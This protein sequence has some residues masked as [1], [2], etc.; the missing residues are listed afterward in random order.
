[1]TH[2]DAAGEV[3]PLTRSSP[4]TNVMKDIARAEESDAGRH[5]L[6]GAA[7]VRHSIAERN[8]DHERRAE[9][10]Q[11]VRPQT[12]RLAAHAGGPSRSAPEATTATVIRTSVSN[13]SPVISERA[14][15]GGGP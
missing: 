13:Q 3:R 5:P 1:M 4:E 15:A 7:G 8:R 9:P 12:G 11:H 6:N 10:H 2:S 14:A